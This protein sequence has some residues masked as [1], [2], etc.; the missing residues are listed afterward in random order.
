MDAAEPVAARYADTVY[1]GVAL[2]SGYG[3]AQRMYIHRGYVLD[4]S[5]V[6]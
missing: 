2:H 1:L 6:W 4:G 3:A 5:G